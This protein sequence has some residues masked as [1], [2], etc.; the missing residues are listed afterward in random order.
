[1]STNC[2]W[3]ALVALLLAGVAY[4]TLHLEWGFVEDHVNERQMALNLTELKLLQEPRKQGCPDEARAVEHVACQGQLL[5]AQTSLAAS[6]HQGLRLKQ[7]PRKGCMPQ[8]RC[9]LLASVKDTL[10]PRPPGKM[11]QHAK[12]LL[13]AGVTATSQV[14]LHAGGAM[15]TS[16]RRANRAARAATAF[17]A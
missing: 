17:R 12:L 4:P 3:P 13:H 8:A 6:Q 7:C 11:P 10:R 5:G 1:M 16:R 15:Q 2:S 14:S 9:Q